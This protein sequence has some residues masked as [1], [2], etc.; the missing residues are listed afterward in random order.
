MPVIGYKENKDDDDDD[1]PKYTKH[2]EFDRMGYLT[3]KRKFKHCL[4][5]SNNNSSEFYFRSS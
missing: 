1:I 3:R 4:I 5:S 2:L